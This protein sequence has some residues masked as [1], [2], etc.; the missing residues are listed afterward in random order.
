MGMTKNIGIDYFMQAGTYEEY[1]DK[2]IIIL[3]KQVVLLTVREFLELANK[4]QF[5]CANTEI[6]NSYDERIDSKDLFQLFGFKEVRFLDYSEYHGADIVFDLNSEILKDELKNRF[7]YI[8]D[9]GTLEHIFD[10]PRALKNL[11]E[12]LKPGGRIIHY[13]AAANYIDHGFYSFSPTFFIE[14]YENNNFFIEDIRLLAFNREDYEGVYSLDCRYN[15]NQKFVNTYV[16]NGEPTLIKCVAKKEIGSTQNGC[17]LQKIYKSPIAQFEKHK[18][19]SDEEKHK[20]IQEL[21]EKFGK[22]E[23]N[24][25]ALY[26][27]GPTTLEV[28]KSCMEK[29]Q[30]YSQKIYGIFDVNEEN[31][32]KE[33][34]GFQVLD[35]NKIKEFP[36]KRVVIGSVSKNTH[37]IYQ[38]IQYLEEYGIEIIP[39]IPVYLN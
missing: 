16:K 3:G 37:L 19:M 6:K 12:M 27:V 25:T 14:Y 4:M 38:R 22:W 21:I 10:V 13:V 11:N 31:V 33:I 39:I 17:P 20:A 7:D 23:V 15:D 1:C 32:D 28:I 24:S 35:I 18:P 36:I 26:G 2:S 8:F 34:S 29:G 9:G 5:I 30:D